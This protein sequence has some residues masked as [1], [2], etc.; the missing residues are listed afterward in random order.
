MM[1]DQKEEAPGHVVT[2]LIWNVR[3]TVDAVIAQIED[4]P[5]AADLGE[6]S[7]MKVGGSSI[8]EINVDIVGGVPEDLVAKVEEKEAAIKDGGFETRSTRALPP[9]P[10]PSRASDG[11]ADERRA[12]PRPA[13]RALRHHQALRRP[14][15]QRGRLAHGRPGEVVAMLGEN[16]A[17]KSTLMKVVYGLVRPDAGTVTMDGQR[18]EI[19]SPRDAMAAGIGMVTQEFLW[20]TR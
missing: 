11:A 13:A 20:S 8:A 5:A 19:G 12:G 9:S 3:P 6:Y 15:G 1:V 17:G 2:S 7:F 16:G 10:S 4:G 18:L 14:G